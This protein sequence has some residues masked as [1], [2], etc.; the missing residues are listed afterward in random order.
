MAPFRIYQMKVE[1]LDV[2]PFLSMAYFRDLAIR[3]ALDLPYRGWG[4]ALDHEKET[5]KILILG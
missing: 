3:V 5:A 4:N 2:R 1:M